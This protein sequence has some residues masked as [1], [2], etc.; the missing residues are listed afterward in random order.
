MDSE[1]FRE[2][3]SLVNE[4][5]KGM[6]HVKQLKASS[7]STNQ[8]IVLERML[9]SYEEAL[10]ILNGSAAEDQ[11]ESVVSSASDAPTSSA[12]SVWKATHAGELSTGLPKNR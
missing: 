2:Y 4:I 6:E 1:Q 7:S 8:E 10:S 3:R 12:S 11:C 9:S 5:T